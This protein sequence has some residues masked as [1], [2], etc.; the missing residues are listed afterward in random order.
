MM[1]GIRLERDAD[2][3]RLLLAAKAPGQVAAQIT[4]GV[5]VVRGAKSGNAAYDPA[6]GRFASK[7]GQSP[8]PDARVKREG[9][10]SGV[11]P[12]ELARR[13]DAVRD[14]ARQVDNLD[15]QTIIDFLDGRSTRPL[16]DQEVNDFV[17]FVRQQ[18]IDDLTDVMAQELNLRDHHVKLVDT[19]ESRD[20]TLGVM[21]DAERAQVIRRLVARGIDQ[22]AAEEML[23]GQRDEQERNRV[24][25][26]LEDT[27]E[28]GLQLD[29]PSESAVSLA[30]VPSDVVGQLILALRQIKPPVV[31]V[32]IPEQRLTRRELI[33]DD[34]GRPVGA[35]EHFVDDDA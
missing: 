32:Q 33:R 8:Q 17:G 2:G 24:K 3:V 16:T 4:S 25:A 20:A 9:N 19:P 14:A 7:D 15:N 6:S 28:L 34:H 31:N 35:V 13:R 18:K 10:P 11:D 5:S 1:S 29:M 30:P 12:E 23:L 22:Q 21:S 26:L 27:T